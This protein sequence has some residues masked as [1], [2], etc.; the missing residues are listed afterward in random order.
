MSDKPKEYLTSKQAAEMLGVVVSTIQQWANEGLLKAWTTGGGHRRILRSSIEEM[1][2]QR[3]A[4]QPETSPKLVSQQL[5]VVVVE[6]NPQQIRMYVKQFR[7]WHPNINIVTANDGYEG[8]I[9][10][11]K[12]RPSIIITDLKMP[13]MDGFQM[14]K[15]LKNMPELSE[16]TIVVVTGLTEE[17]VQQYYEL[18]DGV[19]LLIKPVPLERLEKIIRAKILEAA[20]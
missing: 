14:I 10:I 15:A 2:N 16:C 6:D 17:E 8:L 19:E 12:T 9:Q 7:R 3:L 18:P 5:S 11:G 13:N 1:L 4:A 20:A